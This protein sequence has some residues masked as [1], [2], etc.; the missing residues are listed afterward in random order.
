MKSLTAVLAV[1]VP[2][3]IANA[4]GS[5][6]E[7]VRCA[8]IAFSN[9]VEARDVDAFAALVEEEARFVSRVT[10]RGRDEIVQAWRVFLDPGG[11]SIR[12]RPAVVE[13]HPDGTLALSRGPYRVSSSD[14]DGESAE[15]WGHFISTWRRGDDGRWRVVFDSGGDD[16]M[17]PT[18]EERTLLDAPDECP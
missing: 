6:R 18:A 1:L 7:T 17:T 15:R 3:T 12:W 10:S 8:E 4:Q 2:L 14:E 11:P 9:A 13:V 16:G 5:P